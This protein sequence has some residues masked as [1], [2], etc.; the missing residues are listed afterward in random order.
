MSHKLIS[1]IASAAIGLA[2]L[3]GAGTAVAATPTIVPAH[4][5]HDN[6]NVCWNVN[7]YRANGYWH[8]R[9][10][11]DDGR[12]HEKSR[13]FKGVLKEFKDEC[14]RVVRNKNYD[15]DHRDRDHRDRDHDRDH[16]K[17]DDDKKRD[18]DR[19]HDKKDDDKKDDDKKR[20]HD[21]DHDKKDDDKK[22]DRDHDWDHRK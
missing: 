22:R 13:T 2:V 6:Y 8:V 9:W 4:G 21:R 17:K 3:G 1:G 18:H 7:F 19:D 12:H 11:D 5:Y 15:R 10:T 16:D 20:D 14:D